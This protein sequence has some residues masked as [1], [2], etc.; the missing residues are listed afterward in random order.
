LQSWQSPKADKTVLPEHHLL[1]ANRNLRELLED[2]SIPSPIRQALEPEFREI[3]ALSDK[4]EREEIHIAAFGRVGAGKSSLLNALLGE[5]MFPTS[6]L[7][8]ETREET[9][10]SWESIEAGHIVLIDSLAQYR[11]GGSLDTRHLGSWI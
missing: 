3:D 6:P 7:H 11:A 1:E 5:N 10:V 8:G 2:T 4:L 9:P